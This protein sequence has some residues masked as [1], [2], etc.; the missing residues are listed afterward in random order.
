MRTKHGYLASALLACMMIAGY[1][2]L[3]HYGF[4]QPGDARPYPRSVAAAS[5]DNGASNVVAIRVPIN[6][7]VPADEHRP[8][9]VTVRQNHK[10]AVSGVPRRLAIAK[11]RTNPKAQNVPFRNPPSAVGQGASLSGS[12]N[13]PAGASAGG[14]TPP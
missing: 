2:S 9:R 4:L 14:D 11:A 12:E 3:I 10:A 13:T 8:T 6:R 7:N 1:L 5:D